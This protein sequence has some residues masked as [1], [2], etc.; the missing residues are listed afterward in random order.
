[1]TQ[2]VVH[3]KGTFSAFLL[4]LHPR[5]VHAETLRLSL[6]FG[7]GGMAA[8]LLFMLAITGLLQLLSYTPQTTTAYNS[9][10]QMY[11]NGGFAGFIRNAHYWSGHLLVIITFL[12]MFRVLLTGALSGG[13][14]YN[15]LIGITLFL[16][17]L[18]ANFTG[19]LMPW[20]QLA[21]WAVT[22]FTSM[23]GYIP[24]VGEQMTTLVRGGRE[25]G[26][27]TLSTFFAIHVGILPVLFIFMSIWH[28]WLVR[29]AGGLVRRHHHRST[30]SI[31]LPTTP[32][33]IQ[34][35]M[36][37]GLGLAALLL[38]FSALVD[39]PLGEEANPG[40]SPNPAK[41]AWYFMGLQ[42]LLLHLHPVIVI[43]IIPTLLTAGLM[44]LPFWPQTVLPSGYWF[45][46]RTGAKIASLSFFT[47]MLSIAGLV[48]FDNM[49]LSSSVGSLDS[50]VMRGVAPLTAYLLFLMALFYSARKFGS[51]TRAEAAIAIVLFICANSISLTVIGVWFR[52]PE[53]ALVWPL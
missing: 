16:L 37:V 27:E 42:E 11:V 2:D 3:S 43:C 49:V 25:V 35:E 18:F 6:S 28:F 4:H 14:Q 19:Y 12:H 46:T 32:H 8:T 15:W 29:K 52:G 45:G 5:M 17:V 13:R 9:I 40:A 23:L 24:F 34:R 36:A 39:A 20:D 41:A 1:M 38:L 53:M 30:E 33:L 47:G 31:K 48:L 26:P 7:L 51:C 10:T 21:Y 44:S 22:I 50:L